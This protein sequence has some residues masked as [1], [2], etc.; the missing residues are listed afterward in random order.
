MV[1]HAEDLSG[2]MMDRVRQVI[3]GLHGHDSLLQFGPD[4]MYLRC[5]SCGYETPG[6]ELNDIPHAAVA[7]HD[8]PAQPVAPPRLVQPQ[9][10]LL[11]VRRVA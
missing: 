4:R 8:A 9:P 11:G 10:Q 2:R 3:C 6:W 1:S 7:R 5:V